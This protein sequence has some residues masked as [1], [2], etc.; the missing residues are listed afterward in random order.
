MNQSI[1]K[2]SFGKKES[3]GIESKIYL[4][5]DK[6]YVF[7]E[8]CF[9]FC[10]HKICNVDNNAFVLS[11]ALSHIEDFLSKYESNKNLYKELSSYLAEDDMASSFSILI[12]KQQEDLL[13]NFDLDIEINNK[14]YT[15]IDKS[16]LD[17]EWEPLQGYQLHYIETSN[18]YL[19]FW[20]EN[21]DF[22]FNVC[23]LTKGEFYS[24]L[25][26]FYIWG[27]GI[28]GKFT[29]RQIQRL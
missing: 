27:S 15:E 2:K 22:N 3:F 21:K 12:K 17:F 23:E 28:I 10:N 6:K 1:Y 29:R 7:G 19:L 18:K 8:M 13:N 24:V 5:K 16:F 20:D 9:S 14:L 25:K 11:H 4:S 26:D